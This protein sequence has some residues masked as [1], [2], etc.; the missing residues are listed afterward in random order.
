MT[1]STKALVM[2]EVNESKAEKDFEDVP[3]REAETDSLYVNHLQSRSVFVVEQLRPHRLP[4]NHIAE[5]IFKL[6][7][8]VTKQAL[9]QQASIINRTFFTEFHLLLQSI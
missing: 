5:M 3:S 8:T 9:D 2:D 1:T 6:T 4:F 7:D